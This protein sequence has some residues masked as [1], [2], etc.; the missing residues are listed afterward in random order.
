MPANNYYQG[1]FFSKPY[2]LSSKHITG[3]KLNFLYLLQEV[4]KSEMDFGRVEE[5]IKYDPALAYKLL[6]FINS[7]AFSLKVEIR[8]VRQALV[9]L[10]QKEVIKWALLV[11]LRNIADE[12]PGELITLSIHRSRFC[13]IL[14]PLIGQKHRE[15]DFFLMGMF[16]LID[17]FFDQ[18]MDELLIQL[19]IPDDINA[20]LLGQYVVLHDVCSLVK[21]YEKGNWEEAFSHM[22]TLELTPEVVKESYL[23]SLRFANEVRTY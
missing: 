21:S 13:E 11:T 5:I 22:T 10:G 6:R 20:A 4:R 23:A 1:Y 17:T 18:P 2:I 19:P 8:S 15:T 12:K 14:A 3:Q 7:L 9:L 16:S